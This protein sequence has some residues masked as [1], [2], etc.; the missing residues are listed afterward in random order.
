[1]FTT[2]VIGGGPSG[3][4]AA[5]SASENGNSVLLIDK[6]D[7]LGR[8]L[9]ISGGGRCNVT[10]RVSHE[11]LIQHLPGNGKF[12][13]SA[14]NTFDNFAIIDYFEN[15][16]V[17][18]KEED[19]G[20]MFPVS[21]NAKDVV[22]A[23]KQQL[24]KNNVDIRTNHRVASLIVQDKIKGVRLEDGTE[25]YAE[26]I[27]IATGGKS[28]PHTG[29]TGDGYEFA[30][31]AGHT[32]T[33]LFPTE[34]PI[35]SNA[36]FIKRKT[37]QGL[38]LRNVAL[39]VLRKNGKPR[40]TH[41]MDM[42]FTHFGI[43]GPAALRCSQFVY[44]EQ[45]SQKKQDITMMIDCFPEESIGAL[46]NRIIPMIDTNKDKAIKNSLKGLVSER[47]LLFL[48][49]HAG[50]NPE[51]NGHHLKKE[52]VEQFCELLKGFKF[53]VNGT[54]SIEKAFVTGG[55]V[56]VKEI[57]PATMQSKLHDNLY[58]CGEVLDIHGYTGGYNITS[59]LVTGYV[60]GLNCR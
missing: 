23:L 32:I 56:T 18:L 15:L 37:L 2:I 6:K 41:Q 17:R 13:Y 29:S 19:H 58:F 3:L 42:I 31:Q 44:K 28:V 21:D 57:V 35:I 26:N 1:M 40:I 50:L 55:G 27:I 59:A 38:S 5:I 45:K 34:V 11:E 51:D 36:P 54:Q 25:I 20:R 24:A 39:S 4:M 49:E 47:Y 14:F 7:K 60:A 9:Q 22:N 52:A 8:K 30:K 46:K 53:P 12:L 43:S 10:N 16:G 33:E 48:L